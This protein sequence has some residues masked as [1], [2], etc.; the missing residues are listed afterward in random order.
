[1]TIEETT[2]DSFGFTEVTDNEIPYHVAGYAK[3]VC[4]D[5]YEVD[6]YTYVPPSGWKVMSCTQMPFGTHGVPDGQPTVLIWCEPESNLVAI[7]ESPTLSPQP[8]NGLPAAAAV[9]V[10]IVGIIIGFWVLAST[11][12][13]NKK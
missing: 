3:G 2:I 1:M 8:P 7:N 5:P 9:G 13:R 6:S 12:K 10:S 11:L 4:S